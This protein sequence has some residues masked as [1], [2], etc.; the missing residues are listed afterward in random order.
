[1]AFDIEGAR[2]AGY[3]DAEIATAMASAARFDIGAAR[4]HYSDG[5]IIATL[6]PKL[7]APARVPI[8][9]Q[10]GEPVRAAQA[11]IADDAPPPDAP[12]PA[13]APRPLERAPA[14]PLLPGP[15]RT[16]RST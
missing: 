12:P 6:E 15:V 3:T 8:P 9:G 7:A 1:M 13:P 4:K 11:R 5:E 14:A 10:E 2:K 16:A